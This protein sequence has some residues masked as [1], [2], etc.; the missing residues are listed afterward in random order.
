MQSW[1]WLLGLG[2]WLVV[3]GATAS[4]GNY[5]L[6]QIVPDRTLT[7]NSSVTTQDNIRVIE[8][9]TQAGS[10][11][12]H[13]FE[14]FSVPT[15][16]TAYFNNALDIQSIISRVT[17][18]SIS[19]IDGLLK[20]NGTANLFLLNPNGIIFGQ[21]ASLDI[22][23]SFVA[24]TAQAIQFGNQGFFNASNPEVSSPLL[25]VNP[26]AILFNQ[27]AAASI[28]NNSVAPSG[29][30]PSQ[31]FTARG[32]RVRDGQS[33]L[34]VGSNISMDG[35][36]LFAFGGRVELG[37]LAGSGTVGLNGDGKNLSL[38]FPDGVAQSDVALTNRS[39][40]NVRAHKDGS[41]AINARNVELAGES[42]LLAGIATG[43]GSVNSK[44]GNIEVNAQAAVNFKGGSFVSNALF[45]EAIGKSG[46]VTITTGS[47]SLT[48]GSQANAGTDGQGDGGKVTITA[49]DTISFDGVDDQG[50]PTRISHNSGGYNPYKPGIA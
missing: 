45:P 1:C 11:L 33:L 32:L 8:G 9:G 22:G 43:L 41:I 44:A 30:D 24:T 5:A 49:R 3:W 12:F 46:D 16:S 38:S 37:G 50:Y 42:A 7:N 48:N 23:G 31:T 28:Q 10:N 2:S 25:T 39:R 13:S 40:V 19:T 29:L 47:L 35:G 14:E 34:L 17:G 21:G 4:S 6:A 18:S 20:A 27:I 26:S 36:G 15:G